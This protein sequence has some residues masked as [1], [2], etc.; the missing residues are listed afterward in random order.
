M[1]SVVDRN[2]GMRRMPVY[3]NRFGMQEDERLY[4]AWSTS[5]TKLSCISGPIK[6][7]EFV[8]QLSDC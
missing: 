2:V 6:C 8:D 4:P 5:D 3:V 7:G 1:R